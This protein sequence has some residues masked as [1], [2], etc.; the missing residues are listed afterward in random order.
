[1]RT[2]VAIDDELFAKA[3]K[4]AGLDEKSAVIRTALQAYVEREAARRLAR[5]G[6]SMPDAKAPPRRRPPKFTND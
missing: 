5:M 4:F 6:G 2:T 3:Q 1:M